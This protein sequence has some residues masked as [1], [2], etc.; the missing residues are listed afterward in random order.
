M[1]SYWTKIALGAVLV[2]GLGYAAFAAGRN[3]VGHF[4]SDEGITIPLGSFVPFKLDGQKL[5]TIRSITFQRS[6]S[7]SPGGRRAL[8]GF[9]LRT[10]LEDSAAF[11]RVR[12]CKLSVTDPEHIDE[13]TTFFCLPADSGYEAFGEVRMELRV[14]NDSRTVIQPL[15]LPQAVVQDLRRK[16]PLGTSH[17]LGDSI[18]AEVRSRVRVQ[19]RAYSDSVRAVRL[20][21]DARRMQQQADS[22]KARAQKPPP[23]P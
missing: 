7:E 22:L 15:L 16:G 18:A 10:R 20:E 14:G 21:E 19:S 9:V 23:T 3:F 8:S 5:G 2:F 6:A 13:R 4:K 1:R 11:E 17:S 12:D